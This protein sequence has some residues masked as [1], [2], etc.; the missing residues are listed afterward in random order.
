MHNP[1]LD[2]RTPDP[3]PSP[4]GSVGAAALPSLCMLPP[5]AGYFL[6]IGILYLVG[7]LLPFAGLAWSLVGM[8][9]NIQKPT[10]LVWAASALVNGLG[11][12]Y[13]Y[14]LFFVHGLC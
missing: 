1:T 8:L 10:V 6:Q 9:I 2:Y 14:E 7:G 5:I 12:Y 4:T 3:R 13:F 11:S